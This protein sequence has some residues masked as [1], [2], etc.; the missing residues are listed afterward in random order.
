MFGGLKSLIEGGYIGQAIIATLVV[1]TL[2][3]LVVRGSMVPDWFIGIASVIITW[4]FRE[5]QQARQ[6]AKEAKR[7]L[8]E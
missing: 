4:Y 8:G 5:Q 6:D 2:C 3:F 1:G 7:R